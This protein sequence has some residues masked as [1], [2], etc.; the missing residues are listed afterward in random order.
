MIGKIQMDKKT[1]TFVVAIAVAGWAVLTISLAGLFIIKEKDNRAMNQAKNALTAENASLKERLSQAEEKIKVLEKTIEDAKV[2][3]A[4]INRSLTSLKS[5]VEKFKGES[6]KFKSR[7][8]MTASM[9]NGFNKKIDELL[10]EKEA[11]E[12]KLAA[13]EAE[14]GLAKAKKE[15]DDIWDKLVSFV[16]K[17]QPAD[18]VQTKEILALRRTLDEKTAEL[19]SIRFSID[20]SRKQIEELSRAG[21]FSVEL[22]SIAV[23]SKPLNG[24]VLAVDRAYNFVAINL[25]EADGLREGRAFTILRK[26][27]PVGKVRV[28]EVR[29]NISAATV[30][31]VAKGKYLQEGDLV[32]SE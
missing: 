23:E 9:R 14:P 31:N 6:E 1:A 30:E 15:I 11:L 18:T 24:K 25:G 12:D 32:V 16:E 7:Y 8:K 29:K 13:L 4:E 2:K 27:K 5:S 19:D 10:E 20:R 22:A 21:V 17:S 26:G 28:F 3:E